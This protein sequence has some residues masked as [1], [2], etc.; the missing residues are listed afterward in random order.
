LAGFGPEAY[1]RPVQSPVSI[2]IETSS[3]RGGVALGAGEE[4]LEE[5]VF[6]A[7]QRQS[8]QLVA[9]LDEMLRRRGLKACHVE[10]V[11]VSIGPGSFTGLRVGITVA[12]TLAQALEGVRCVAVPTVRAIAHNAR[13]LDCPRVGVILDAKYGSIYAAAFERREGRLVPLQPPGILPPER[14]LQEVPKPV[15]LLGEGLW[16]HDLAADGVSL[17]EEGL[18]LPTAAGVWHVGRAMASAGQ[19]TPLG[20]LR[21]LYLRKPEAVRLWEQRTGGRKPGGRPAPQQGDGGASSQ[22]GG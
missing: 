21:P 7:E 4:L 22:R 13:E 14:F 20:Q 2:A 8:V 15:T 1:N 10:E 5:V 19:F 18:W 9:R 17:A 12:R 6:R 11:Y 16:Y 3:R